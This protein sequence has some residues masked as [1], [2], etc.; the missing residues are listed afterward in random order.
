M[1]SIYYSLIMAFIIANI[2]LSQ[3]KLSV[4]KYEI[5]L[6]TIYNGEKKDGKIVLKNIGTDTLR[7]LYVGASC[8]CTTVKSPKE[9]LLPG[10]SDEI[11]FE[12]SPFGILGKVEK[13]INITTNDPAS[14]YV[15][16]RIIAEIKEVL[17]SIIGSNT[18]YIIENAVIKKPVTKRMTMKNVSGLPM[19]ILGDSLSSTSMSV[20]MDKKSLQPND[21]LN[22]DVTVVPDKL[23]LSNETLYI[24]TDFKTYPLIEIKITIFGIQ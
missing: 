13:S 21:T 16:V 10:Q 24:V 19:S 9:F 15:A 12:F 6:G 8:G 5:D 3:P 11:D 23:G 22:V 18:L 1:K 14:Q 2:V 4:D 7:I 17:Q 20:T